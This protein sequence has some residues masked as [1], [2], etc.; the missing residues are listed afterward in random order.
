MSLTRIIHM[1]C[2]DKYLFVVL[3]CGKGIYRLDLHAYN[4]KFEKVPEIGL[5]H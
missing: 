2:N 4:A 3:D 5:G 1:T